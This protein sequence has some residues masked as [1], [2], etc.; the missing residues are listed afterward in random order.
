M[1]ADATN[2]F[3]FHKD[4]SIL[5]SV[6]N[7]EFKLVLHYCAS[8]KLTVNFRKT[9]YVIFT[10][11]RKKIDNINI[12]G[13]EKKQY[14]KYLGVYLDEHLTWSNRLKLYQEIPTFIKNVSSIFLFKDMLKM[15]LIQSQE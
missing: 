4:L 10:S 2:I 9:H 12:P 14:I 3:Y 11:A 1:F 5:E 7:T 6:I 13:I 8:N 15:Y